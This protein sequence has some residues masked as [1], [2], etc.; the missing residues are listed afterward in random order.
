M[1]EC[2]RTIEQLACTRRAT[3]SRTRAREERDDAGDAVCD[4]EDVD[5]RVGALRTR[6]DREVLRCGQPGDLAVVVLGTLR[7]SID[8]GIEARGRTRCRK[9]IERVHADA[10]EPV[11]EILVT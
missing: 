6:L 3:V 7:E 5:A 9:P 2:E 1:E 10:G 4:A 11:A 8:A